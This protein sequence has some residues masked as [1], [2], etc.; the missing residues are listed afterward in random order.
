[1]CVVVG[2]GGM[3]VDVCLESWGEMW[4]LMITPPNE[5]T[6]P[7]NPGTLPYTLD[8]GKP[9]LYVVSV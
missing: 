3:D 9:R 7:V 4:N 8:E 1:M 2:R 5:L 6:T